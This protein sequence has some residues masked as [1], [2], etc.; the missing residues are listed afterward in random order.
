MTA[1]AIHKTC[2]EEGLDP[3]HYKPLGC[4]LWPAALVDYETDDKSERFLLTVYADPTKGIFV[5]SEDSESD[6][7]RFACLVDQDEAYEPAYKSMEGI[8][9]YILGAEFYQKLDREAEKWLA[10]RRAPAKPSKGKGGRKNGAHA[11]T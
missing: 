2:L 8:L 5:E 11:R 6:E 3:W 4:S 9:T 7:N 10:A 1:C